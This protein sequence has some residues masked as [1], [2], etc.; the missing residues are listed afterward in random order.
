MQGLSKGG[1]SAAVI[2]QQILYIA[3][4][5]HQVAVHSNVREVL[6]GV[7]RSFREMLQLEPKSIVEELEVSWKNGEYHLLRNSKAS[8][9]N[10][11]LANVL[12][13]L[14]YE[15]AMRL[16]QAC[17]DLMWLHAGAAAYRD[18][19]VLIPG[20]SGRGKSTLV[21]SLCAQ[22]WTYLS[23][24]IVPLDPNSGKV[25]PFPRLPMVRENLGQQ[26][27]LDRVQELRKTEIDLK[28]EAMCREA[29][30]IRALVFPTYSPHSPTKILPYSPAIAALELLE[31]CLNFVHHKQA[32]V[33]Y[34]CELVKH[35]PT[36]QMSYSSGNLAAE[37]INLTYRK[38]LNH[39]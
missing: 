28:P 38:E 4:G 27:P 6:A 29:M 13:C 23:D 5:G 26:L 22:G 14:R 24:D 39:D 11:T 20:L 12:Y 7:E 8:A 25:I 18:S 17:P 30:P 16:I 32:A 15:V 2:N 34:V 33:R 37:L 9:K 1:R 36:F 31:N 35:L 10:G 3:F 19:A 21:T